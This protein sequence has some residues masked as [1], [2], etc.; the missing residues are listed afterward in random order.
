MSYSNKI[1]FLSKTI[2]TNQKQE[3]QWVSPFL[4][5]SQTFLQHMENTLMKQLFDTKNIAFYTRYVD[6]IP[7]IYNSQHTT[8]K[9]IHNY[10][11]QVHPNL[12]LNTTY[13]N[14]DSIN[15]MDL[16]II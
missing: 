15:F 13:E 12:Q 8:P 10:I 4:A 6:D 14:N 2:Y 16:L 3:S 11:N 5:L 9:T 7:L 1:T